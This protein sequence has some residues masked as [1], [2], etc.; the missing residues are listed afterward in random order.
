M[1]DEQY[2][3][4]LLADWR[5]AKRRALPWSLLAAAFALSAFAAP[6]V[7]AAAQ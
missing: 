1:T 3:D 2:L 6:L 4:R 5:E 7:M